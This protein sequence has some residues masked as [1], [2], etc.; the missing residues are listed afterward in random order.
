MDGSDSYL[1]TPDDLLATI[2][3]CGFQVTEWVDETAWTLEWFRQLGDR[4]AAAQTAATLPALLTEGPT[5]M[6]NFVA[7]VGDGTLTIRRGAFVLG[8]GGP[9][10][11]AEPVPE[12]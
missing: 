12:P 3:D 11:G 5:R 1:P 8:S 9:P 2:Q 4:M 10:P 6:L 7:A